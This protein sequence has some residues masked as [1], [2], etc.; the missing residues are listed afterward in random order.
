VTLCREFDIDLTHTNDNLPEGVEPLK[1]Y[2]VG[3]AD[4]DMKIVFMDE[5]TYIPSRLRANEKGYVGEDEYVGV[6]LKGTPGYTYHYTI[7]ENDYGKGDG[8]ITLADVQTGFAA[9]R[10]ASSVTSDAYLVGVSEPKVVY[11]IETEDGV[12]YQTYGLKNGA[13]LKYGSSAIIPYNKAYLR[14]PVTE[15]AAKTVTMVFSN[16]D[17]TTSIDDVNLETG[18]SYSSQVYNLS[19][20]RVEHPVKGSVYVK[21]GKKFIY[22]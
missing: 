18:E 1:A 12:T 20:I 7:G 15:T 8:Q 19:G 21:N 3:D 17:G 10:N 5:V 6:V 22:N 4:G 16:E 11:P 14:I 13:F 2:I 9:P